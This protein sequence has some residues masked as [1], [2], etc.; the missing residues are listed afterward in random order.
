MAH[1]QTLSIASSFFFL[2]SKREFIKRVDQN[3]PK[4]S[5]QEV[6]SKTGAYT[7]EAKTPNPLLRPSQMHQ[8]SNYQRIITN[9]QSC[10]EYK[11]Y[12]KKNFSL[13]SE[14]CSSSKTTLFL[15]FHIAQNKQQRVALE[16][17]RSSFLKEILFQLI[18]TSLVIH[19]ISKAVNKEDHKVLILR[20]CIR[21]WSMFTSSSPQ[22]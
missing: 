3:N 21:R 17:L 13:L 9:D 8:L 12:M 22:R 14:N 6:Y 4:K 2:I 10:Q 19:A 15:S 11:E 18:I 1:Y 20:Q 16:I 5:I 7:K